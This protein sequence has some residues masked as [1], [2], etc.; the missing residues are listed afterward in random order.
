MN[1]LIRQIGELYTL[2][3]ARAKKG[4]RITSDDL[5]LHKKAAVVV[6]KGRIT[7][8]GPEKSIPK[9]F[10]RSKLKEIRANHQTVLPGFVDCHTHTVF[11][12]HRAAEFELRNQGV[13]YKEIAAQGGGI[14]STMKATRRA[15]GAQLLE[16]AQVRVNQFVAQGVTTLEIK[17][18]YAL[19]L[20]DEL[21]CL[22]VI[23]KLRGPRI[24]STF[25]GAHSRPPEFSTNEDY[26][27][28]LRVKVLPLVKKKKLAERVDIF[29]EKGFFEGDSA[30]T[31]MQEARNLGFKLT[32]HADQMS[33]SG[34]SG[35]G[36]DLEAQSIDHAIQIPR[37]KIP[38]LAQ[39]ETVAV[40]LP[41]ADV[42]LKCP[43]PPAREMIDAGVCVALSTDFNPGS[44]PSQDL[45]WVGLLARLEMKMTLAE[46]LSAFT[47]G[48]ATALGLQSETGSI[49]VGKSA[50]LQ[51]LE[52]DLS[53]LFYSPGRN[54]CSFAISRGKILKLR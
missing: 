3:E 6:H 52:G 20:K 35:A 13:S 16:V 22:Q 26:L 33:D 40:L 54:L 2:A 42:Y 44:S 9:A 29:W 41:V 14:L 19:N 11:A 38:E 50:D 12:G 7:W 53:E 1:L 37:S 5:S 4:R 51:F 34:A 8:V 25:L 18:G 47:V 39:S 32:I 23:Q 36:I 27:Q 28:F 24:V 17:T 10:A 15:N 30:R 49:E 46:V 21:K 31:Y 45:Q 48:G 43:F